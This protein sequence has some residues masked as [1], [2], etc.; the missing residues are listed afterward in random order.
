MPAPK[1]LGAL[2]KTL[3]GTSATHDVRGRPRVVPEP[4]KRPRTVELLSQ[5]TPR[6]PRASATG[7]EKAQS[8]TRRQ[9]VYPLCRVR[10][11]EVDPNGWTAIGVD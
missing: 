2:V 6:G 3:R 1:A 5:L 9:S 11:P 8:P 7:R 10:R 4:R